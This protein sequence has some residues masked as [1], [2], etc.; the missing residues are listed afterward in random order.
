LGANRKKGVRPSA[1]RFYKRH[2]ENVNSVEIAMVARRGVRD[3]L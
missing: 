3:V 2:V 1:R